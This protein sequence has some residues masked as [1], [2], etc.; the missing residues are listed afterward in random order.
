[1]MKYFIPIILFSFH[2]AFSFDFSKYTV[3]NEE[4]KSFL[5]NNRQK[6][7][8]DSLLVPGEISLFGNSLTVENDFW[9]IIIGSNVGIV[10]GTN[11]SS[12]THASKC[13]QYGMTLWDASYC[14]KAAV[15]K[16]K[17]EVVIMMFGVNEA[18]N[19]KLN[20]GW[21]NWQKKYGTLLDS[22][23]L[24]GSVP[25]I[26][27]IPPLYEQMDSADV[28]K[29]TLNKGVNDA[30][31]SLAKSKHVV[32]V[33]YHQAVV[34]YTEG[35]VFNEKWWDDNYV[36]P[37][38][39]CDPD[40]SEPTCGYG[41]RNAV[42]WHAVNKVYRIVIDNCP[43]DSEVNTSISTKY[44]QNGVPCSDNV[45]HAAAIPGALNI[46]LSFKTK[47]LPH[48]IRLLNVN[49]KSLRT[50]IT[51]K[52]KMALISVNSLAAGVYLVEASLLNGKTYYQRILLTP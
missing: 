9:T 26:S 35:D 3:I 50:K 15:T 38:I 18:L 36:H 24:I 25:I 43:P 27:T 28:P 39:G 14:V 41:I 52:S 33:D 20:T 10:P 47:F 22:L 37:S 31:R 49:G 29:D 19:T 51:F 46:K 5:R 21:E 23:L 13:A 4:T 32:L 42:C 2:T 17:P 7:D 44:G 12:Y 16:V 40:T 30:I 1:M 48:S 11:D 6:A 45:F 34:D 8:P